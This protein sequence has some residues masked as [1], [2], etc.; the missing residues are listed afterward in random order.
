MAVVREQKQ[1]LLSLEFKV[2][3]TLAYRVT[4]LA[5]VHST[6]CTCTVQVASAQYRV[7]LHCPGCTCIVQGAPAQYRMHLH[8][9]GYI[10]IVQATFVLS[11]LVMEKGKRMT[12]D[13]AQSKISELPCNQQID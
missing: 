7:H 10:C 2:Q 11:R 8:C 4:C 5:Q 12:H 1:N 13:L 3:T 6:G 9:P